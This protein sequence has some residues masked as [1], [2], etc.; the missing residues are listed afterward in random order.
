MA[1]MQ[2]SVKLQPLLSKLPLPA[3]PHGEHALIETLWILL[4][5]VITVP[6][7]CSIPGGSATLGFLVS[8]LHAHTLVLQ[9][10]EQA[11]VAGM[12]T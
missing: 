9:D 1:C 7:V 11:C 10:Q 8:S 2:L 6:V 5:S 4:A 12:V 3:I